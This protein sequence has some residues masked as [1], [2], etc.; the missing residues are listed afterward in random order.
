MS[1]KKSPNELKESVHK[2]W[3][4]GLGA[5]S[6]AEQEG[7]KLFKNLVEKGEQYE[8]RGKERQQAALR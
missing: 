3:L 4:A 8:S 5:M 6:V 1:E 7:S 2:I